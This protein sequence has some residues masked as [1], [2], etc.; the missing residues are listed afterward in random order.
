[1]KFSLLRPKIS[2]SFIYNTI[3]IDYK[4]S[5]LLFKSDKRNEN[6]QLI[7]FQRPTLIR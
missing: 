4:F 6:V 7:F 1:M 2:L 3:K 5:L